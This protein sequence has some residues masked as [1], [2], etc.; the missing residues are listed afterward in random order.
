MR[1]RTKLEGESSNS[2]LSKENVHDSST[3]GKVWKSADIL[4]SKQ[5][6]HPIFTFLG[7]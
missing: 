6:L 3:E 1:S 5:R 7:K 2:T 4:F